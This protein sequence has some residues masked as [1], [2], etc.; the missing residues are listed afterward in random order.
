M[1]VVAPAHSAGIVDVVVD[2]ANGLSV[3]MAEGYTYAS[4]ETFD[5]NGGWSGFGNNGQDNVIAFTIRDNRL[6]SVSCGG[7]ATP[8]GAAVT[9]SPPL[10][11]TRNTFLFSRDGVEFSG[12]MVAPSMATGTI[13]L[14]ECSSDGWYAERQ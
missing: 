8:G 6:L 1:L 13:R 3:T 2:T 4:P 9:L 5:F 10:T 12:R 7:I 11:L 14:G